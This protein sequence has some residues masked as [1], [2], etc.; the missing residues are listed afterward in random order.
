MQ[1]FKLIESPIQVSEEP[2]DTPNT[3]R[4]GIAGQHF[5]LEIF[6]NSVGD[7]YIK[8]A[9]ALSFLLTLAIR[10]PLS[11]AIHSQ[12]LKKSNHMLSFLLKSRLWL[13]MDMPCP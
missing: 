5:L 11:T 4:A 12:G 13:Q 8:L 6:Q 10:A 1:S 9:L 3:F 7:K 2:N